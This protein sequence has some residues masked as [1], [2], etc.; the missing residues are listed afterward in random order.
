MLS[1]QIECEAL[2]QLMEFG[3]RR[4]PDWRRLDSLHAEPATTQTD[5]PTFNPCPLR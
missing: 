3:M 1:V 4:R 2:A 5:V